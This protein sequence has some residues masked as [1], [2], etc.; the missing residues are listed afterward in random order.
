VFLSSDERYDD[1]A[2]IL[3]PFGD[4][5][6]DLGRF[7]TPQTNL[8]VQARCCNAH[9]V[10][11]HLWWARTVGV[12]AGIPTIA[13]FTSWSGTAFLHLDLTNRWG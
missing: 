12:A 13:C 8:A 7:L 10:R 6:I 4:N 5:M 3:R 1:H 11:G 2:D 9:A